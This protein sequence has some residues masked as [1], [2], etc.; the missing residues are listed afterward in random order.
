MKNIKVYVGCGL[1]HVPPEYK[2]EIEEFKL[3]LR[4]VSWITVL[5]FLGGSKSYATREEHAKA[6]YEKDIYDCVGTCDAMIGELSYPSLGLGWEL[7]TAVEKHRVRTIMC[8]QK[9]AVVSH[10]PYGA[11]MHGKN[12]HTSFS[13]YEKNILELKDYFI[14]EL[15]FVHQQI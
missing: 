4:K 9:G 13:L 12:P 5:D 11:P 7:G 3:E 10:L 15:S 1:T 8:A 14:E 2:L 6:V